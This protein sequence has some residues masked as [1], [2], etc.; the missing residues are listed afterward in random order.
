MMDLGQASS[1]QVSG[2]GLY[3]VRDGAPYDYLDKSNVGGTHDTV[4]GA[5]L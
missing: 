1:E 2:G 5:L 4:P 3:P